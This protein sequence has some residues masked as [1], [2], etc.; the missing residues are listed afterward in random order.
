MKVAGFHLSGMEARYLLPKGNMHR[1][2]YRSIVRSLS[3]S[4]AFSVEWEMLFLLARLL[5]PGPRY[6]HTEER[7]RTG[8]KERNTYFRCFVGI[9]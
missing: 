9:L 2:H 8:K 4:A 5:D 3:S 7:G 6:D 1:Y